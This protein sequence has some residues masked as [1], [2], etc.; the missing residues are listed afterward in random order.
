MISSL[1]IES[2]F[3]SYPAAGNGYVENVLYSYLEAVPGSKLVV[4]H[5]YGNFYRCGKAKRT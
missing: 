3:F 5:K 1:C 2:R 4:Y